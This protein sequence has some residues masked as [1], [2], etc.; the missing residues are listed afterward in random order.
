MF[1]LCGMLG[2]HATVIQL[3]FHEHVRSNELFDGRVWGLSVIS[4]ASVHNQIPS[5]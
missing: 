3:C 1:E 5:K 4:V 2:M